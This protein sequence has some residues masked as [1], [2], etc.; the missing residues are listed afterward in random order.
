MFESILKDLRYELNHGNNIT[1]VLLLYAAVFFL[2]IL[3]QVILMGA[4]LGIGHGE[5]LQYLKLPTTAEL[6]IFRP[7]TILTYSLINTGFWSI[8][9][10]L[11]FIYWFGNIAGDLIGDRRVLR[12]FI[13]S[14]INGGLIAL[15][16]CVLLGLIHPMSPFISG[17]S[18]GT[19]GLMS[20]AVFLAPDYY[21]RLVILGK[22]KIKY[23]AAVMAGIVVLMLISRPFA[24]ENYLNLGGM[25]S[26][27]FYIFLLRQGWM[28]TIG[29]RTNKQP[30]KINIKRTGDSTKIVN[31][32][33]SLK[34]MEQKANSRK[35]TDVNEEKL[36][37]I[38][39]KIKNKGR[40]SLSKEELDFLDEYSNKDQ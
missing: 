12:L 24:A 20:G 38:L 5:I 32:F 16:I 40:E 33:G 35:N 27:Y 13:F 28:P 30:R 15:I 25:I 8:V 2:I 39:I 29:S 23:I 22:V 26:G 34:Q 19:Y 18:A 21:M 1:R 37:N 14:V 11:L 3:T 4:E 36:D 7:W 31:I 6:F 17:V 10:N 9:F